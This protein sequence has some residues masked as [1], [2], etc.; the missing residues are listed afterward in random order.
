MA[1][2]DR[3]QPRPVTSIIVPVFNQWHLTW[4]CLLA[5]SQHTGASGRG[6]GDYEVIVVDDGSTDE[7]P[8]ALPLL[9]GIRVHRNP[10]NAGFAHSC[11]QGAR[12]ARGRYLLFLNNDTE[13]HPGWL[14]PMVDILDKRADVAMVGCKLLFP[15]GTIQHG[16]VVFSYAGPTP[17]MPFHLDYRQRADVRNDLL[18]LNAVTAACSLVRAEVF[19]QLGGFDEG[20]RNGLED[21]DLCLRLKEAGGKILYTPRST[22]THHESMSDGRFHS[23]WAN[24][25]RFNETWVG[26][27]KEYEFDFRRTARPA[28]VDA[29]RPGV[30]V[31]VVVHDALATVAPCLENVR[32]TIGPQ[33]RLLIVDD[34][35]RAA[36][37][38]YLA[39]FQSSYPG[40]ATVLRAETRQGFTAGVARA[41]A[42]GAGGAA[43]CPLA[44]VLPANVKVTPGWLD[45][46]V[47]HLRADQR[48]GAVSPTEGDPFRLTAKDRLCPPENPDPAG[49]Q[50]PLATAGLVDDAAVPPSLCLVGD[51]ALFASLADGDHGNDAFFGLHPDALSRA[52]TDQG[53]RLGAAHDVV[54]YR[55]EETEVDASQRALRPRYLRQQAVELASSTRELLSLVVVSDAGDTREGLRELQITL[56]ALLAS[57]PAPFELVVVDDGGS[58]ETAEYLRRL[59]AP[60]ARLTIIRNGHREGLLF[61]RNQGLAAATG[62]VVAL[63]DGHLVP[64]RGWSQRL[65]AALRMDADANIGGVGPMSNLGQGLQSNPRG[66]LVPLPE[67]PGFTDQMALEHRGQLCFAERL[68]GD[69]VMLSRELIQAIGGFDTSF[70]RVVGAEQ[71]FCQRARRMGFRLAVAADVHVHEQRPRAATDAR[72]LRRASE[73]DKDLLATRSAERSEQH[74]PLAHGQV[75]HPRV[76]PL[77]LGLAEDVTPLLCIP[78]MEET[79]WRE[80]VRVFASC[81]SSADKVA[82]VMRVEPPSEA[83]LQRALDKVT[84]LLAELGIAPDKAPDI[85]FEGTALPA[86]R[87]GGLYTAASAYVCCPGPRDHGWRREAAA[88]GLTIIEGSAEDLARLLRAAA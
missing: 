59:E 40:V 57:T 37:R 11:N 82:L 17:V 30:A 81:F 80:V 61:S 47:R 18:E 68:S 43:D 1:S 15:N 78:D 53:K 28:P 58:K 71:D 49:V 25:E 23:G 88:C 79:A 70:V 54:V 4:K 66:T 72:V 8:E 32:L 63:V 77:D 14:P 31:V 34:G 16:G 41:L 76:P 42:T 9:E 3:N 52:L 69:F 60:G 38:K 62:K 73:S 26:R 45:R 39:F 55:F 46:L 67:L 86:A 44:A 87:R 56:A 19:Q 35:C 83:R 12:L 84:A 75:F 2:H 21:V 50:P 13:V 5:V 36:T 7:T 64:G 24:E 48:L 10:V 27:I 33:D 51:R 74:V 20:Y 29:T 65:A 6:K 85:V 22:V